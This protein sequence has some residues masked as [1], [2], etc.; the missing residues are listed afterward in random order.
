MYDTIN[1]FTECRALHMKVLFGVK[2]L[3]DP[4]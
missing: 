2:S 1:E 3:E 4:N